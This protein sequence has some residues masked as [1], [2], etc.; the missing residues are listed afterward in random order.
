MKVKV[1]GLQSLV[2]KLKDHE[3]RLGRGVN[4]GIRNAGNFL[5]SKSQEIVPIDDGDLQKS[6]NARVEGK[7]LQTVGIIGYTEPYAADVHEDLDVAH[8]E[9]YNRK[10]AQQISNGSKYFYK[11]RYK[12]YHARRP[13]EQPKFLEDALRN[14]LDIIEGIVRHGVFSELKE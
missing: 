1:G 14:N 10:H 7:G 12:P 2:D 4:K 6:G 5:L 3:R 9:E 11:G 13:L 8:G